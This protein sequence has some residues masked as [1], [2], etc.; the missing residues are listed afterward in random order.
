MRSSLAVTTRSPSGLKAALWTGLGG[1]ARRHRAAAPLSA[2]Q[3]R[4]V[5]SSLAVTT[6]S[7]SGLK[8]AL[9]TRPR[10]RA[11]SPSGAPL[12]ASQIR[13]VRSSLAVTTRSPS[14]LK[15]ALLTQASWP[16]RVA[17]SRAA[18][19]VPDPRRA[20]VAR[21]HH[22]LAVGAEGGAVDICSVAAQDRRAGR[23]S[24]ASQ[25]RAVPSSHAVTT[26]SPSGLKAALSTSAARGRAGLELR[27]RSSASQIRAVPSSL[28]VTTRSPSGLKAAL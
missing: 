10:G 4:A 17:S 9:S 6:R 20:V 27:R 1:R 24:S 26:R 22:P 5:P 25:I 13:A 28:A 11:G 8:A 19:G 12:S 23:R 3:I 2:S 21:G 16:R 18:L 15:A 7:P 14:G